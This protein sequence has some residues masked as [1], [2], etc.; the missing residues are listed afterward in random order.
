MHKHEDVGDWLDHKHLNLARLEPGA[1]PRDQGGD[2]TRW[3]DR[4]YC[5]PTIEP[6][7][8]CCLR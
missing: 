7:S 3:N 5:Q 1:K 8:S 6:A 4:Q 2:A